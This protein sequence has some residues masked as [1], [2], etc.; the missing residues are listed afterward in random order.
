MILHD[1]I[2]QSISRIL[3]PR[4]TSSLTSAVASGEVDM[5]REPLCTADV[6]PLSIEGALK[7]KRLRT[8]LLNMKSL[9]TK[10]D[11]G[12]S[13]KIELSPRKHRR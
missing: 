6:P 7:R 3:F 11:K 12:Q 1:C 4:E 13:E 5:Q 8:S 9:V 10:R 2:G